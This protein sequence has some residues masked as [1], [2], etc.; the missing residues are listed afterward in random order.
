[1]Y[2][3]N[4]LLAGGAALPLLL[5]PKTAVPATFPNSDGGFG[6]AAVVGSFWLAVAICSVVGLYKP[7]PMAGIFV[8]QLLYKA[9]WLIAFAIPAYVAGR[10]GDVQ[11]GMAGFFAVWFVALPLVIPWRHL[12]GGS[13]SG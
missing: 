5:R 1:M 11:W 7:M 13:A 8:V 3:A 2:G 4:I 9:T 10:S 12:L 6:A